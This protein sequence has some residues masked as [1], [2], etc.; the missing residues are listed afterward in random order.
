M[1]KQSKD[2]RVQHTENLLRNALYELSREKPINKITP[3]ELCRQ[4]TINRNTFYS[5]HDSVDE[6]IF[7]IEQEVI[8]FIK[9]SIQDEFDAVSVITML[10]KDM[11]KNSDFYRVIL[12]SNGDQSFLPRIFEIANARNVRK[13]EKEAKKISKNTAAIISA[14]S[15]KGGCA[16]IETWF[17]NGMQETPEEVAHLVSALCHYG[18]R[19]LLKQYN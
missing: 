7:S 18:A 11:K 17:Q 3:T 16:V 19:G 13:V 1:K 6:F 15:V 5:H 2:I 4:A 8:D 14:F 12:S 10:C 9:S